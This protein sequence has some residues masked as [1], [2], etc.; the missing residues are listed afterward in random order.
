MN[1]GN[2]QRRN[3]DILAIKSR[4]CLTM[5]V[6]YGNIDGGSLL[7]KS[8]SRAHLQLYL[9]DEMGFSSKDKRKSSFII[10]SHSLNASTFKLSCFSSDFLTGAYTNIAI[11]NPQEATFSPK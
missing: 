10:T 5:K 3:V 1:H 6:L 8:R 9:R 2:A 7:A 11:I 4:H